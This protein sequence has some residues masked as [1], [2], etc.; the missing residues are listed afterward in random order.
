MQNSS[1]SQIVSGLNHAFRQELD[2]L[3]NPRNNLKG[4]TV[5]NA[6]VDY[7][8]AIDSVMRGNTPEIEA[9]IHA[10]KRIISDLKKANAS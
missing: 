1:T 3:P 4:T 6:Q 9:G 2:K 5:Y 8:Y 7:M 10:A